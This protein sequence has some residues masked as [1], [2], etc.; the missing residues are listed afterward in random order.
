MELSLDTCNI[1][2]LGKK[3]SSDD[4]FIAGNKL[5]YTEYERD[6]DILVS[7]DDKWHQQVNFATLK[8]NLAFGLMKNTFS[9]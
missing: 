4:Y 9:S 8:A 2:H 6:L 5:T 3:L 1:M 7:Y